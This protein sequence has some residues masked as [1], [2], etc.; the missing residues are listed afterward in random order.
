MVTQF[1]LSQ[2]QVLEKK[3]L[4]PGIVPEQKEAIFSQIASY[5]KSFL[6]N[7]KTTIT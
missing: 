3:L 4:V 7:W 5:I 1:D 2:L 6:D